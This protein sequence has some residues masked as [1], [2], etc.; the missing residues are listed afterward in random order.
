MLRVCFQ[1]GLVEH[2]NSPQA[3]YQD[4]HIPEHR[5]HLIRSRG[6]SR[7]R[8]HPV[9]S[10]G[11]ESAP[12]HTLELMDM[13]LPPEFSAPIRSPVLNREPT[14]GAELNRESSPPSSFS[15]PL[16]PSRPPL[17]PEALLVPASSAPPEGPP[18][19]IYP[20]P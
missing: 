4:L 17:S 14:H 11:K 3:C 1:M 5:D 12:V 8:I 6:H 16:V 15:S 18:V 20:W 19:P 2:S 13:V 10:P 9:F 7:S